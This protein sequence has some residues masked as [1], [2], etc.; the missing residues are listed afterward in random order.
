MKLPASISIGPLN[1]PPFIIIILGIYLLSYLAGRLPLRG[2]SEEGGKVDRDEVK[3]F[4]E[5]LS[6]PL[7]PFLLFWKFSLILTDARDIIANPRL[8]LF[9][10]GGVLN[11]AFGVLAAAIWMGFRWFREKP[12]PA[13]RRA[14]IRSLAA[15]IV[16]SSTVAGYALLSS[17]D[18]DETVQLPAVSMD[19]S[20]GNSWDITDAAGQPLVLNFWASWCPPCRAEM[21]M[22]ERVFND[23]RYDDVVFYAVNATRTEKNA[24]DGPAWLAE[25]GFTLPFLLDTSGHAGTAY[26]ISSL[27]TTIVLDSRSRIVAI[28]SG[29]VSRS[30]L[31]GAIRK[32]RRRK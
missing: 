28:R 24:G 9:S 2:N 31:T 18:S 23:S 4:S 17:R 3:S 30:W 13:V 16:L 15:G 20:G 19:L 21:P 7:L 29:A 32:A 27:P 5:I 14:L 10:T 8:L 6:S 22:L 26:G 12:S 1:I 25:N 11:I